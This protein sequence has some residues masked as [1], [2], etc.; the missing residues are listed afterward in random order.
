MF[1]YLVSLTAMFILGLYSAY[2]EE[3]PITT[4]YVQKVNDK[5]YALTDGYYSYDDLEGIEDYLQAEGE[6]FYVASYDEIDASKLKELFTFDYVLV[7]EGP[8]SVHTGKLCSYAG[9]GKAWECDGKILPMDKRFKVLLVGKN[10]S[11]DLNVDVPFCKKRCYDA[12]ALIYNAPISWDYSQET[13]NDVEL[14]IKKG[15]VISGYLRPYGDGCLIN[16]S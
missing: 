12:R 1:R 9:V 4:S 5:L 3:I 13:R 11:E 15:L 6:S 10:E 2:S 14:R 7:K 8:V 16:G